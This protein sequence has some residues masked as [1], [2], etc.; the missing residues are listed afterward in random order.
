MDRDKNREAWCQFE[1]DG[2]RHH[3]PLPPISEL[4]AGGDD[5]R[6]A[7]IS[8]DYYRQPP[9]DDVRGGDRVRR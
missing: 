8:I 4:N 1:I 9:L 2:R 6:K 7:A 3:G 5:A